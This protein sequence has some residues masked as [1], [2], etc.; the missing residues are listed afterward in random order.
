[1][2]DRF[3]LFA[4]FEKASNKNLEKEFQA[5]HRDKESS[6]TWR[7]IYRLSQSNCNGVVELKNG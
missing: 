2:R 6:I 4:R 3:V 7:A 1:M 5:I